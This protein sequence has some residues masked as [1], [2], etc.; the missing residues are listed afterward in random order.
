MTETFSSDQMEIGNLLKLS[1]LLLANI[2]GPSY[3]LTSEQIEWIN[4]FIQSTPE[5]FTNIVEDIKSITEDGKINLHDIPDI[6]KLL[7]DIYHS[8]IL[9][10]GLSHPSTIIAF[11]KYTISVIFDSPLFLLPN[12][13]KQ[14]IEKM[15]D[16][17][18]DLL[19]I[20]ISLEAEP[21][22]QVIRDASG[23]E[24]LDVSG[25]SIPNVKAT[26]NPLYK[27]II[28]ILRFLHIIA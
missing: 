8:T 1:E 5:A 24:I 21:F 23:N 9:R 27:C 16:S 19:S 22:S 20:N 26:T 13:E 12:I 28:Q 15:I 2:N 6:V 18:L 25:N 3:H 4:T 10:E 11:I 14:I 17:S 7:A